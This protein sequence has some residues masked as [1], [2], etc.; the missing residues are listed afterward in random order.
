M[1]ERAGYGVKRNYKV[2][3]WEQ[4]DFPILCEPC[5]GESLHIRLL[6]KH[7]GAECKICS[8]PYTTFNW[9]PSGPKAKHKRTEICSTCAKINN[10]CQSCVYDL[11]SNL[12]VDVRNRLMG[13]KKV[14]LLV[15]EGNRDIFT[16]LFEAN[17][18]GVDLPYESNKMLKQ[19]G[20]VS[21]IDKGISKSTE[22]GG[23]GI[24]NRFKDL[25]AEQKEVLVNIDRSKRLVEGLGQ[26]V[27]YV[28]YVTDKEVDI[29]R[30]KITTVFD[31]RSFRLGFDNGVVSV[32]FEESDDAEKFM[33]VYGDNMVIKGKKL[34]VGWNI[35]N[36][37]V[38]ASKLPVRPPQDITPETKGDEDRDI[39][40]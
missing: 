18:R 37:Y 38:Y 20:E 10:C 5:L 27:V 35:D 23:L 8:R 15:S 39:A 40:H 33:K 13:D 4:N 17:N 12:P 22:D 14:E 6:K 26:K 24:A 25:K 29:V 2:L 34:T 9:K 31:E 21:E 3:N 1:T 36:G 11:D 16:S 19:F 7:L 28:K 30:T 32:E